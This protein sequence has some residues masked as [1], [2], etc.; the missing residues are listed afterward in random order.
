[1]EHLKTI[2]P[3]FD[4][5]LRDTFICVG[6]DGAYYLTGSIGQDIWKHNDGIEVWRSEDLTDWVSLGLVWSF[7]RDATWQ[8]EW[9]T[10]RDKPIRSIWAPEIHYMKGNYFLT[11]ST[12]PGGAGIFKSMS[13]KADGPYVNALAEDKPLTNDID[14]SLFEDDDGTVYFLFAGGWI[15]RMDD[16]MSALVEKPRRLVCAEK[17]TDPNRHGART[18]KGMDDIGHEGAFMFKANGKYYLSCADSWYGR[19][20]SVVAFSDN[21]YGPYYGRH[22]AVPC[23][24]HN[25][26]FRDKDGQWYSTYFGNDKTSPFRER[27]AILKVAFDGQG[28]ICPMV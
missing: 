17:D 1:M 24:G 15:A 14:G 3:L 10:H 23:G 2:K 16:D 8:K 20:S 18:Y 25:N 6:H 13:G 19:Y 9:R 7:E 5:Q 12:P 21:I 27:P 11:Y 28:M 22:E 4:T 26:Y